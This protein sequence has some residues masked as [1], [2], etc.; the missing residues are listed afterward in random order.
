MTQCPDYDYC[1]VMTTVVGGGSQVCGR[2]EILSFAGATV[3]W[4]PTVL[5][6][7]KYSDAPL[8]PADIALHSAVG[9]CEEEVFS[10]MPSL[11]IKYSPLR[12]QPWWN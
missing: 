5:A 7:S 3:N 4:Q 2:V 8:H 10:R 12:S 6:L 9:P 11:V 1:E